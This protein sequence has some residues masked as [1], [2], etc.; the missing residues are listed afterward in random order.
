[1]KRLLY[2]IDLTVG[3]II[4]IVIMALFMSMINLISS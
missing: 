1:M 2:I 3:I 4:F